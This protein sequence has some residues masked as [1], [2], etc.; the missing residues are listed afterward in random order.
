MI[1]IQ[2]RLYINYILFIPYAIYLKRITKVS[3]LRIMIDFAVPLTFIILLNFY[4]IG[5]VA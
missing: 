4:I 3:G 1:T 2:T 5:I